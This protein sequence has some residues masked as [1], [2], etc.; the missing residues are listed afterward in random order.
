[1]NPPGAPVARPVAARGCVSGARGVHDGREQRRRLPAAA[2]V[3]HG[4]ALDPERTT[5]PGSAVL[6]AAAAVGQGHGGERVRGGGRQSSSRWADRRVHA[7][8]Y[9]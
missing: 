9:R 7:V 2:A 6:R 1:M 4:R 8:I 5:T 3:R